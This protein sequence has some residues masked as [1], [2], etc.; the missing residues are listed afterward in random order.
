VLE[1]GGKWLLLGPQPQHA[2]QVLPS[3]SNAWIFMTMVGMLQVLGLQDES[4]SNVVA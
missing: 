4:S 3:F 1:G 2:F